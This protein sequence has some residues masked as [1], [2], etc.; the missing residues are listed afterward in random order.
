MPIGGA[1]SPDTMYVY[2]NTRLLIDPVDPGRAQSFGFYPHY[3]TTVLAVAGKLRLGF[4]PGYGFTG[5]AVALLAGGSPWGV[6]VAALLFGAL[7]QGTANL[8]LETE[9]VTRDLA[10]VMRRRWT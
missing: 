3:N 10:L 7:H 8:D 6:L 4:S 9:H 1:P 5:I 2:S